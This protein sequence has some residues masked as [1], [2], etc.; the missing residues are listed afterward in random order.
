MSIKAN[1]ADIKPCVVRLSVMSW[2]AKTVLPAPMIA[3]FKGRETT[4]GKEVGRSA[5]A[6]ESSC[7]ISPVRIRILRSG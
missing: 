3:I 4:A 1:V 2:R 6:G 5:A 7:P